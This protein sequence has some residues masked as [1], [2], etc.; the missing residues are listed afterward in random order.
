MTSTKAIHDDNQSWFLAQL[1]PNS[2]R[3]AERNLRRQGLTTFL[4]LNE[5]T[6]A[7]RSRFKKTLE[8]LFPGYIFVAFDTTRGGWRAINA[9]IGITRLVCFGKRPA[10]V[11]RELV[12]DLLLR[13]DV[14]GTLRAPD[15]L[16]KGDRVRISSG[17]FADFTTRIEAIDPDRRVWVLLELMGRP[18]RV[19]VDQAILRVS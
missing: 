13:C 18:T 14:R 2:Y 10:P 12:A 16:S 15:G 8:P 5:R 17:P 3:I 7:Q 19:S 4:P 6:K 11:P 9:T 1:K